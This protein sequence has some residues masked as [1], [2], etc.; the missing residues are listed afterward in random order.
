MRS[1]S[2]PAHVSLIRRAPAAIAFS[3]TDA[4]H[5][6]TLIVTRGYRAAI[7]AISGTTRSAS[8]SASTVSPGPALTPPMSTMLAPWATTSSHR[9]RALSIPTVSALSWKESGV[10]L[11]MTTTWAKRLGVVIEPADL[12]I[13]HLLVRS[14]DV[15]HGSINRTGEPEEIHI[16][17]IDV[18]ISY[19]G[20][21]HPINQT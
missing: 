2:Q 7:C 3:A 15:L 11:T 12:V 8:A 20:I 14:N 13:G 9:L 19:Q 4:R 16:L 5:V 10:R 18:A 17:R 6:S 1:G 21:S